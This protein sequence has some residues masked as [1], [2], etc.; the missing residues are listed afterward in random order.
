[1]ITEIRDDISEEMLSLPLPLGLLGK[2]IQ[3]T[4]LPVDNTSL[5]H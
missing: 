3:L 1:M 2:E 5:G 4:F